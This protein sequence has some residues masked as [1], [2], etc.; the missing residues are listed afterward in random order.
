MTQAPPDGASLWLLHGERRR[1][2]RGVRSSLPPALQPPAAVAEPPAVVFAFYYCLQLSVYE[3]GDA[4][5][6]IS[7][8]LCTQLY[9]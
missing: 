1:R 3:D 6:K 8:W 7:L 9:R 5:A 2:T 4:V